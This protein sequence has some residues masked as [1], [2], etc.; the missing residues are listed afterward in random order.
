VLAAQR[1]GWAGGKARKGPGAALGAAGGAE[2]RG[3]TRAGYVRRC[4]LGGG[5]EQ[6]LGHR[7]RSKAL[8]F[9]GAQRSRIWRA[10]LRMRIGLGLVPESR[11]PMGE[12]R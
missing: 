6:E 9:I 7:K 3:K 12:M 5:C 1:P 11:L 10:G 2:R 4:F 8:G